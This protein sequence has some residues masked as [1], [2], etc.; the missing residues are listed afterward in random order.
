MLTIDG[1]QKSGSGTIVR[2]GV[3]L[4]ALVGKSLHLTHI[5][6]R[7]DP[8]GLRPQHLKAVEA[9]KELSRGDLS[10]ATVGSREVHF[11]PS[12]A[13][14]GGAYEWDIGTAGSTTML[15]MTLLPLAAFADGPCTFRIS[16]GLFQDFAPPAFHMQQALLPLLARMGLQAELTVVRPGYVP[17]GSGVIE[18]RT[19]PVQGRLR[20]LRLEQ[21]QGQVRL[22]GIALSS[23]L[24]KR[25]VSDRMAQRCRQALQRRG[26][27][28]TFQA[29]YD[30]TAPQP[31]AA[32]ALFARDEGGCILG[33]DQAGAPGRPSEAIGQAVARMLL[34]DLET[35]ATVD[36]HLADQLILFAAL[37]EG[38][39]E[40][41][42]PRMTEHVETNLWLAETILN[43]KARQ[44]EYRLRIEGIGY[45]RSR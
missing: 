9:V 39:S 16:G 21:R 20:P 37:A 43:A 44:E 25:A 35:G 36:R 5:R 27:D 40:Y 24:K 41:R 30:D 14:R 45:E 26:L 12:G 1:A 2:T 6:A 7:R 22:G 34:E 33:A 23:H 8:P 32:L 11:S 29:L 28:A 4:A 38:I 15:A 31:G 18:L 17:K 42:I 10:G 3:A 13:L 19:A